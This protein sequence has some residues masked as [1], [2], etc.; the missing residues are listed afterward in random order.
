MK[1]INKFSQIKTNSS[2]MI[3]AKVCQY[4]STYL[5]VTVTVNQKISIAHHQKLHKVLS[6]LVTCKTGRLLRNARKQLQ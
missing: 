6:V 2:I 5:N 4:V 1:V 3:R